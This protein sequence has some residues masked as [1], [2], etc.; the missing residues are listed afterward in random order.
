MKKVVGLTIVFLLVMAMLSIASW[1][2]LSDTE[3]GSNSLTAGTFDLKTNDANGVT[4]T[5]YGTSVKAQGTIGPGTVTLK[6]SGSINAST[7]SIIF[8]Y[9]ESDGS[10]N[11]TNRTADE[12]ASIVEVTT[13]SYDGTSLLSSVSDSNANGYKDFR[14]LSNANLTALSGINANSTKDFVITARV[15]DGINDNFQGDGVTLTMTFT[16]NQ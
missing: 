7:L 13:L 5:L 8:N 4:Q 1:A 15:R 14:D 6:N 3:T 9:T 2:Y 11:S 12:T 16:L 10:P